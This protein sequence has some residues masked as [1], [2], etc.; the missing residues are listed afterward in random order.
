[1]TP[2]ELSRRS[3]I[4]GLAA[5]GL[6]TGLIGSLVAACGDGSGS[7]ASS[8][9]APPST[10]PSSTVSPAIE[11]EQAI[12]RIGERYREDHPEEDDLEVLLDRLSVDAA[13]SRS[14]D[15]LSSLDAQ[16]VDDYGAGRTVR[17]DGWVLSVTESRAAAL[18]SLA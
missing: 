3:V 11:A 4:G 2:R 7:T 8:S 15:V 6:T 17:L 12:V 1:M 18:V 5:S 13:A 9:T 14:S 10:A 16:V